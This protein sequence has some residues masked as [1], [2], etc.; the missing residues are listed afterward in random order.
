MTI[1][2]VWVN[3]RNF[4]KCVGGLLKAAHFEV[5][6]IKVSKTSYYKLFDNVVV[7]YILINAQGQPQFFVPYKAFEKRLID[8]EF[9][10]LLFR[11]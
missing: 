2:L 7:L 10:K 4:E 1:K 9:R 6:M 8:L 5:F 3:L 11:K